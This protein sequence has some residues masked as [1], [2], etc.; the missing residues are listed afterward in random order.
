MAIREIRGW[1]LIKFNLLTSLIIYQYLCTYSIL[2]I[3]LP[4]GRIDTPGI[5]IDLPLIGRHIKT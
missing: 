3:C 2:Q 1:F 5:G 4:R